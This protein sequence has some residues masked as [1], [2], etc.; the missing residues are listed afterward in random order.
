MV[1]NDDGRN[2]NNGRN[3]TTVYE[4]GQKISKRYKIHKKM[5][6]T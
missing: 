6:V 1:A 3:V 4:P 2:D 5:L